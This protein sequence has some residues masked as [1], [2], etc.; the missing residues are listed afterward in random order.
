[1]QDQPNFE[2]FDFDATQEI[3]VKEKMIMRDKF[4]KEIDA[5]G[6]LQDAKFAVLKKLGPCCFYKF[7]THSAWADVQV[8][9]ICKTLNE[10][11]TLAEKLNP[12][13]MYRYKDG[14]LAFIPEWKL[15]KDAKEAKTWSSNGYTLIAPWILEVNQDSYGNKTNAM[16]NLKCFILDVKL[17]IEVNINIWEDQT[18]IDHDYTYNSNGNITDIQV[19]LNQS[20]EVLSTFNRVDHFYTSDRKKYNRFV[21]SAH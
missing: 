11:L 10:G 6:T 2:E 4:E 17:K 16:K 7:Y 8:D 5:L 21:V 9:L 15:K 1:M 14:C 3:F 20:E 18:K 19:R 12:V 13:T